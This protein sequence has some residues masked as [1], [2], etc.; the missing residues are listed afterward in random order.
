MRWTRLCTTQRPVV[1][2]GLFLRSLNQHPTV[3]TSEHGA[4]GA[5]ANERG[6]CSSAFF[7]LVSLSVPVCWARLGGGGSV[8]FA[9]LDSSL[10][11]RLQLAADCSRH[12]ARSGL[13]V[14]GWLALNLFVNP[15]C[16]RTD[17]ATQAVRQCHPRAKISG[18]SSHIQSGCDDCSGLLLSLFSSLACTS[19]TS[20]TG[21]RHT[22]PR[23]EL[24]PVRKTSPV[25]RG[26]PQPAKP[27][28][29][30]SRS[31]ET[32]AG[33]RGVVPRHK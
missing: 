26:R 21:Q 33:P 5:Q 8:S 31:H 16:H 10:S 9:S 28:N 30:S 6:A 29:R 11:C 17:S 4:G 12:P 14:C 23:T 18:P 25:A 13:F 2:R 22:S 15:I 27:Q 19:A 24:Y 20:T 3:P 7:C 1:P 32:G